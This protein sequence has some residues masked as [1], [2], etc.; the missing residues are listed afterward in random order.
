MHVCTCADPV[1]KNMLHACF[2]ECGAEGK[3]G[4]RASERERENER[5]GESLSLSL[6]RCT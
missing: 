1:P 3:E 6:S 4:A 2:S 5:K